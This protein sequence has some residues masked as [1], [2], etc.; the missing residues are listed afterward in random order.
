MCDLCWCGSCMSGCPNEPAPPSIGICAYCDEPIEEGDRY[1][2]TDDGEKYHRD[3]LF[4]MEL[5]KLLEL[6][7]YEVKTADPNNYF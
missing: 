5:D 1:I 2:E 6:L 4:E 7:G 3:C